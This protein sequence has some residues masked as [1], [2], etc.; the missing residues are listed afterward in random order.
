MC[1][2][3]GK[4]ADEEECQSGG[5]TT[6]RR[7]TEERKADAVV[8]YICVCVFIF[9]ESEDGEKRNRRWKCGFQ[10]CDVLSVRGLPARANG[11]HGFFISEA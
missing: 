2:E 1:K 9:I 4:N 11:S 6:V 5:R 8:F 7:V 3:G 10:A